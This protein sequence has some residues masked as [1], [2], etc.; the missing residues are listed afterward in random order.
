MPGSSPVR[1]IRPFSE[2][3]SLSTAA[4]GPRVAAGSK[5][6]RSASSRSWQRDAKN[7]HGHVKAARRGTQRRISADY[8]RDGAYLDVSQTAG[9]GHWP[10]QAKNLLQV[11]GQAHFQTPEAYDGPGNWVRACSASFAVGDP[12]GNPQWGT[13]INC[14]VWN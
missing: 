7:T 3:M 10:W 5:R 1:V 4:S 6:T 9:N 13:N 8:N 11:T 2:R 12:W 14:T